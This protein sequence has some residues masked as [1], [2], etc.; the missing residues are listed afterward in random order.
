MAN[1][2]AVSGPAPLGAGLRRIGAA[3]AILTSYNIIRGTTVV[4]LDVDFT[5]PALD[6]AGLVAFV[7]ATSLLMTVIPA[8][9]AARIR[10]AVALRIAD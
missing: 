2:G 5:V 3:L 4:G 1:T 9:R 6:I 8:R 7:V 10:P